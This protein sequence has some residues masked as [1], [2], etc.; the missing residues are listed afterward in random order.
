MLRTPFVQA[1]LFLALFVVTDP[2]TAP[3]RYPDQ[4]VIGALVGTASVAAEALGADQVNLLVALL[5]GNVALAVRRWTMQRRAQ[6]SATSGAQPHNAARSEN[7]VC[8]TRG[9][10]RARIATTAL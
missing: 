10:T 7:A 8:R 2:P 3:S 1:T 4:V 5:V 9:M 6:P